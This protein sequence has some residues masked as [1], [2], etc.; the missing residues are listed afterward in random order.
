MLEA[1]LNDPGL[2]AADEII[3]FLPPAFGLSENIRLLEDLAAIAPHF[4]WS[5]GPQLSST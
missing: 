2:S 4:G 1:V 5:A 3:L